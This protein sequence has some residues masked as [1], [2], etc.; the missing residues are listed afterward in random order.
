VD[1]CFLHILMKSDGGTESTVADHAE[2]MRFK[3]DVAY[4]EGSGKK[5]QKH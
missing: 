2:T 3:Q 5:S 4:R 1:V